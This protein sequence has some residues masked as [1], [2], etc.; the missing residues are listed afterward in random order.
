MIQFNPN[1]KK[2]PTPKQQFASARNWAKARLFGFHVDHK[3]LSQYELAEVIKAQQILVKL[4]QSWDSETE[5]LIG[6][7]LGKYKC[8]I[9]GRRTNILRESKHWP[10]GTFCQKHQIEMNAND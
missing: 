8:S 9:C 2:E 4:L 3:V 1:K 10:E 7:K 5:K 6:R